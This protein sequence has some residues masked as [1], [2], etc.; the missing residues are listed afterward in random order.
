M[1]LKFLMN[2]VL[3]LL[4]LSAGSVDAQSI[5]SSLGTV[6]CGDCLPNTNWIKIKGTPDVSNRN[7]AASSST[8]GGGNP[9][10]G[11]PLPLPPN[12]HNFWITIR[13]LGNPA[14]E[15]IIG[16]TITGM[17]AGREYEI[18]V[19]SLTARANSY[20]PTFNDAF[21]FQL[22]GG[23][24]ITVNPTQNVW[25]INRLRFTATTSSRTISFYP[26][27]NASTSSFQSVNIS[28]TVN[29]INAVPVAQN[30]LTATEV[31]AP[32]TLNVTANDYDTDGVV[33]VNTVDLDPATPGIQ[34][35]YATP[36]G[37][38]T[39]NALGEVTFSPAAG[40]VGVA[41]LPYTVQDNY[42]LDGA[43][44]AATSS[45]AN[46]TVSVYPAVVCTE[47]VQGETFTAENGVSKVISQPATNYGFVFDIFSLD[48]SFNMNINGINLA[49]SELEFQSE[50]TPAPGINIGFADGDR[51]E[52]NTPKIWEMAGTQ[53][54]PLIRVV[55]SPTGAIS[56][57]GSK[58]SGGPLFPLTLYNGNSFNT[59]NWNANGSNEIT[60]TQNVVGVTNITGRGYGLN[61]VPCACYEDP[62]TAGSG[63]PSVH[64]ITVLKRAGSDSGNWPMIRKGAHT[65]LESNTKG[66]VITRVSTGGLDAITA[67]IDGMMVYDTTAKCL[68]IYTVDAADSAQTGW[69]CFNKPACP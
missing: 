52:I 51:Y 27:F 26:G 2:F 39:V 62:N 68:K 41:I 65:V 17:V 44:A 57:L 54:N 19:Y 22:E 31:D 55:L 16:T 34:N 9:W 46:I 6:L 40:F 10:I 11:A 49:A 66:F 58:V 36:Q 32:V 69:K 67:P 47:Q 29:A 37:V 38:W 20:S 15:E 12:G 59:I 63:A 23:N 53:T 33:R 24:R 43:N 50:D 13:D 48:N 42:T 4:L 7:T 30:D 21:D 1:K 60:V 64:G 18:V 56:M 8:S 61:V 35:T 3:G 45:P 28:V 14:T 5:P 25:G